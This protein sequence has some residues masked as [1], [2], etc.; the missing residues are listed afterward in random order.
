MQTEIGQWG[1]SM[2][3]RIPAAMVREMGLKKGSK[4]DITLENGRLI[5]V[6]SQKKISRAERL[7][8]LIA[9]YEALGPDEEI[10]W[11]PD[12]GNEIVE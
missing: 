5:I 12:V 6:P 11:G 4:A 3:L 9:S 1:N 8:R 10:D 7:A 2:A